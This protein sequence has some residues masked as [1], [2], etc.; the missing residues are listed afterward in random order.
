MTE[1]DLLGCFD[2]APVPGLTPDGTW[3]LGADLTLDRTGSEPVFLRGNLAEFRAPSSAK[4]VKKN[5]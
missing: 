5:E 1:N 4:K 2:L 3:D